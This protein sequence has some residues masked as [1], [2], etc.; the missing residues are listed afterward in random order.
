M[1]RT[2]DR[3]EGREEAM[4]QSDPEAGD[5][6]QPAA[7]GCMPRCGCGEEV[8]GVGAGSGTRRSRAWATVGAAR[9]RAAIFSARQN[10]IQETGNI[11]SRKLKKEN[12]SR[13]ADP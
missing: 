9:R 11:K 6:G 5:I 2:P 4:D 10:G 7:E 1:E 13:R 12:R 3:R 8:S